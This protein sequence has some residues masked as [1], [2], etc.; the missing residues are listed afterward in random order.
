MEIN[1]W[2]LTLI[3]LLGVNV[4]LEEC[5]FWHLPFFQVNW[6]ISERRQ[7][8]GREGAVE[9]ME[10][11]G[12]LKK[13]HVEI[14]GVNLERSGIS[15]SVNKSCAISIWVLVFDTGV[16]KGCN[17][18]LQNFWWKL[19]FSGIFKGK[20]TNLKIPRFFQK[21]I[22]STS[23]VD[24][25]SGIP[26]LL[27]I[28]GKLMVTLILTNFWKSKRTTQSFWIKLKINAFLSIYVNFCQLLCLF[29]LNLSSLFY[30][31]TNWT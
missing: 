21:S 16:S 30:V 29:T 13:E 6:F 19:G 2:K 24:F 26:H 7:G 15:R 9:D 31:S 17:T 4:L 8:E 27:C 22:S 12:V 18:I 3:R 5:N 28:W 23:H 14:F 1:A 20:V 25:L 10:F 11:P